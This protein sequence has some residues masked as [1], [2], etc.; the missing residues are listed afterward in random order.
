MRLFK[1]ARPAI[2]VLDVTGEINEAQ[3]LGILLCLR[4]TEW[5]KRHIGGVIVRICSNGGSLGAAQ[6]ICEGIDT[7]RSELDLF[8]VSLVT[9]TALSAAFYVSLSCECVIATPA[10]TL[11]NA[12]AIIGH[13]NVWPLAEKLGISFQTARSGVGKGALHPL[14]APSEASEK[15]MMETVGDIGEQFFEWVAQ[16]RKVGQQTIAALADGRMLSGRQAHAAGLVDTCGGLYT[17]LRIVSEQLGVLETSLVWL[18]PQTPTMV[19]RV[20]KVI[21]GIY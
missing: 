8:T 16:T 11:G 6:A 3:A 18:N 19:G 14:A 12:G 10:A 4:N 17:A 2:A 5:R 15:M 13:I 9:D 21:K 1:Q 7:L 20:M